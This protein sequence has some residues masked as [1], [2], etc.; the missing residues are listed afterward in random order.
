MQHEFNEESMED[1]PSFWVSLISIVGGTILAW[2]GY[3]SLDT[4]ISD[5]FFD[6]ARG[7]AVYWPLIITILGIT[8]LISG[9]TGLLRAGNR[10]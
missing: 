2:L 9:I 10:L 4:H 3:G 5:S 7:P 8:L 1:R 6:A